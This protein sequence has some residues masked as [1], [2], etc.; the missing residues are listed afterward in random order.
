MAWQQEVAVAGVAIDGRRF[1]R[2]SHLDTVVTRCGLGCN[3]LGS[4]DVQGTVTSAAFSVFD[5][6]FTAYRPAGR[7][8]RA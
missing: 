8:L 1:K 7:L 3:Q 6:V 5:L 2:E 4:V